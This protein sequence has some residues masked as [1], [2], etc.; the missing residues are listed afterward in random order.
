VVSVRPS[1][2]PTWAAWVLFHKACDI[3]VTNFS[4]SGLV[5]FDKARARPIISAG[6]ASMIVKGL[7][8]VDALMAALSA[9]TA[10]VGSAWAL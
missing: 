7:L 4:A 2:G 10:P 5:D 1:L 8:A 3:T 6:P 9:L